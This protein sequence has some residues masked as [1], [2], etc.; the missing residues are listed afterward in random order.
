MP[1]PRYLPEA[2]LLALTTVSMFLANWKFVR[3]WELFCHHRRDPLFG[4]TMIALGAT[5][6]IW[7]SYIA[8]TLGLGK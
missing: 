7:G 4:I 2:M 5:N 8:T 3:N 6:M 1:D